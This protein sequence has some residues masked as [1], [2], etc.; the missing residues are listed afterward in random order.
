[1]E[2]SFPEGVSHERQD[3]LARPPSGPPPPGSAH[4]S[5]RGRA[6]AL[7][8]PE[9]NGLAARPLRQEANMKT[10]SRRQFLGGIGMSSAAVGLALADRLSFAEALARLKP[11]RLT[12]G[13]LEPLVE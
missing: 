10:T 13:A 1:M 12:F 9:S 6:F 8:C 11:A 2:F 4:K 3:R 5:R 7:A